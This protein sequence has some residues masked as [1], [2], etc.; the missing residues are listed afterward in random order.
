M[1]ELASFFRLGSA[2]PPFRLVA[3]DIDGTLIH[4]DGTLGQSARLGRV[5]D[6]FAS[7]GSGQLLVGYD[8]AGQ[9]ARLA[10]AAAASISDVVTLG[11]PYG[12]VSLTVLDDA[13]A[14]D[15]W[16]LLQDLLPPTD[17]RGDDADL[18][19]GRALV[20]ALADVDASADPAAELRLPAAGI[21]DRADLHVHAVFGVVNEPAVRAAITAIVASGLATRAGQRAASAEIGRAHV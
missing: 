6:A 7:I 5:L 13:A 21:S 19:R 12:P 14:G 1:N 8:G 4:E 9:A 16:R 3:S 15:V 2:E 17:P 11:T 20:Q 18:G 10:A